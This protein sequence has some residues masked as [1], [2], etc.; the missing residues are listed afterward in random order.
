MAFSLAERIV[1]WEVS[2][3][4]AAFAFASSDWRDL[5]RRQFFAPGIEHL[6]PRAL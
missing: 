2:L 6:L 5:T 1:F 4:S 3:S